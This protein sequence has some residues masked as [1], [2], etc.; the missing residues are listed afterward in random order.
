MQRDGEL[1]TPQPEVAPAAVAPPRKPAAVAPAEVKPAA[2]RPVAVAPAA[3][4]PAVARP[5]QGASVTPGPIPIASLLA[6]ALSG[7]R[8]KRAVW[9]LRVLYL[10]AGADRKGCLKQLLAFLVTWACF[11]GI[12]IEIEEVDTLRD[13][14]SGDLIDADRQAALLIDISAGR[15]H[16]VLASP[17]CNTHSRVVWANALGPAP[18]RS[19]EYPMGF[20]WMR[21]ALKRKAEDANI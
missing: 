13:S 14:V 18:V 5:A 2:V 10:F 20:P 15:W 19:R 11:A 7:P 1:E 21:P 6:S 3:G 9:V 12:E 17:P 16:I 4:K 8:Q